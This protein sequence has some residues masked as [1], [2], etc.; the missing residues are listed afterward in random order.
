MFSTIVIGNDINRMFVTQT[1]CIYFFSSLPTELMN[2]H[3]SVRNVLFPYAKTRSNLLREPPN[4][5]LGNKRGK[6]N[7]RETYRY[8]KMNNFKLYNK[9]KKNLASLQGRYRGLKVMSGVT[10]LSTCDVK[11]PLSGETSYFPLY[12]SLFT[13]F[14][15]DENSVVNETNVVQ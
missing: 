5:K 11:L 15:I 2:K 1:G 8:Y 14:V 7:C 4:M 13:F 9:A 12:V 6:F 3:I 10:I